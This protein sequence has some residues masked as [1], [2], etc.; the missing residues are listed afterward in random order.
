MG[1]KDLTDDF[2]ISAR[3][4]EPLHDGNVFAERE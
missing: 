4:V 3:F 2:G 1:Q